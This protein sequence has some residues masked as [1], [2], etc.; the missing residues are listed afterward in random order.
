MKTSKN[1]YRFTAAVLGVTVLLWIASAV[2]H[3][4]I[5]SD[6]AE[7]ITDSSGNVIPV[8][9]NVTLSGSTLVAPIP[10]DAVQSAPDNDVTQFVFTGDGIGNGG[11][12]YNGTLVGDLSANTGLT[13]TF[14]LSNTALASGAPFTASQF[15]G[16]STNADP[17]IPP[18]SPTLRLFIYG[19]T[20]DYT[21]DPT[22]NT[23]NWWWSN[24]I[25]ASPT[26][27][28][29]GQDVTI[30]VPFDPSQWSNYFGHVGTENSAYTTDFDDAVSDTV[31]MGI[32]FGSGEFF[33]DGFA[34]DTGGD[35]AA[36]LNI[37][38]INATVP[39]PTSLSLLGVGALALL[40]RRRSI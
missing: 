16:E 18:A 5:S 3:A 24:P 19:A 1:N 21:D 26:L 35:S 31:F 33:A 30:T 23:A 39:E 20:P 36:A 28:S 6:W 2:T 9:S 40:R 11:T 37:D 25:A 4:D 32:S 38:S 14:N 17:S 8:V 22:G 7:G 15:V 13:A 10:T 12:D 29:N 27:M 34:F